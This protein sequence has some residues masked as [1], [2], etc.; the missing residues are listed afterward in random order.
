M[1]Q[2]IETITHEVWCTN[3]EAADAE[4]VEFCETQIWHFGPT[5]PADPDLPDFDPGRQGTLQAIKGDDGEGVVVYLE[6]GPLIGAMDAATVQA[7]RLALMKDE[8]GLENA[9]LQLAEAMD[10]SL[11][12]DDEASA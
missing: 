10:P 3:H 5:R 9:I 1:N 6:Y 7:L 2:S 12:P 11:Y 4:G 8:G